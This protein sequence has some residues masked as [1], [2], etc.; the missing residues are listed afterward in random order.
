[1][2]IEI[3]GGAELIDY[4]GQF[5]STSLLNWD[6]GQPNARYRVLKLLRDNFNP[7]DK[8]VETHL[9]SP[10][11]FAQAFVTSQG[12]RKTLLVNKRD[13]PVEV[14][15]PGSAGGTADAV[16]LTTGSSPPAATNL[17]TDEISLNGLAVAVVT[18][19]KKCGPGW[20]K[21]RGRFCWWFITATRPIKQRRSSSRRG[22]RRQPIL[23]GA[24]PHLALVVTC[25]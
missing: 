24:A 25:T 3:V 9:E 20:W 2:G 7:G 17:T 10:T 14:S 21:E 8:L 19:K 5:A 13:R 6:T 1:M 16:D 15:V 4:P 12:E 23:C 11:V 18:L 22:I